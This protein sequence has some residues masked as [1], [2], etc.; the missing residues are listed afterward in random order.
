MAIIINKKILDGNGNIFKNTKPANKRHQNIFFIITKF[1]AAL[2]AC[3]TFF[4]VRWC[5]FSF[6]IM[7]S[8]RELCC[9]FARQVADS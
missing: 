8:E 2:N 9:C 7:G 6:I 1:A 3:R 4:F 5:P